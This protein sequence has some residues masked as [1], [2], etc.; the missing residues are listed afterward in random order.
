MALI[1]VPATHP[2]Q[3]E[4]APFGF[5]RR[6]QLVTRDHHISHAHL[7]QLGEELGGHGL[8]G[9]HDDGLDSPASLGTGHV[10]HPS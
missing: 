5:V 1:A 8:L 4:P 10:D 7:D 9:D 6:R 3:L 2:D